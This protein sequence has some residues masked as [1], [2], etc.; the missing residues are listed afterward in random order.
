M[1][2]LL[3]QAFS[4]TGIVIMALIGAVVYLFMKQ[5]NQSK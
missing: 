2:R 4:T 5:K 3:T 1:K